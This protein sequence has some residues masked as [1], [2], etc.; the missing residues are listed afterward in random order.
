ML[1]QLSGETIPG[2][3]D[4][5]K[6]TCQKL[7]PEIWNPDEQVIFEP[8]PLKRKANISLCSKA[9]SIFNFRQE[10]VAAYRAVE[11]SEV[12]TLFLAKY[13]KKYIAMLAADPL[14]PP[15]SPAKDKDKTVAADKTKASV[16]DKEQEKEKARV[17]EQARIEK[18]AKQLDEL[19]NSLNIESCLGA[20]SLAST[21]VSS[22]QLDFFKNIEYT[23]TAHDYLIDHVYTPDAKET[24]LFFS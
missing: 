13:A 16:T 23:K 19:R 4:G 10:T 9:K 5:I 7:F 21:V 1:I 2:L 14:P 18:L 12:R 11:G 3:F 15:E 20:Q 6:E 24:A 22:S 8:S 17:E